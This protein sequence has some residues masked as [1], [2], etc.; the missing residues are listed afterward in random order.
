M[1]FLNAGKPM[2]ERF[3]LSGRHDACGSG[4]GIEDE[5]WQKAH[6]GDLLPTA[7]KK[8]R[9]NGEFFEA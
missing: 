6:P 9:K 4:Y 7:K 8:P 5:K 1:V 3:L 2:E